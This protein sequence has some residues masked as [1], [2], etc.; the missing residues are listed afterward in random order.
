RL[1]H[2][3]CFTLTMH[4]SPVIIYFGY[5]LHRKIQRQ[6]F[7]Q[8]VG[9]ICAI[10]EKGIVSFRIKVNFISILLDKTPIGLGGSAVCDN[11]HKTVDKSMQQWPARYDYYYISNP[12]K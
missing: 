6:R 10:Y 1:A 4:T 11:N 3:V 12:E 5:L 7:F 9:D 8:G 2:D